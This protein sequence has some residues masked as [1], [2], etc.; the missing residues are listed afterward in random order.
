MK[1]RK[2]M[3]NTYKNVK[4]GKNCIPEKDRKRERTL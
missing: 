2:L 1:S 4:P 3:S